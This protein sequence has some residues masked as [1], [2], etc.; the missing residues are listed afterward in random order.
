LVAV[1][2]QRPSSRVSER[3]SPRSSRMGV[4]S[5]CCVE[6]QLTSISKAS[7]LL[8]SSRVDLR[9]RF[10]QVRFRRALFFLGL[11]LVASFSKRGGRDCS[12]LFSQLFRSRSSKIASRWFSKIH[13][14]S[15]V[16]SSWSIQMSR[17][18]LI[19]LYSS[20]SR[21]L[22]RRFLKIEF[23]FFFITHIKKRKRTAFLLTIQQEEESLKKEKAQRCKIQQEKSEK[24]KSV[25]RILID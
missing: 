12:D 8:R 15:H 20:S 14:Y 9:D 1:P 3:Y 18:R 11:L 13:Y 16:H 25:T 4:S 23:I 10:R 24:K 2:R 21:Q 19:W 5:A 7:L 22:F 17:V 6:F